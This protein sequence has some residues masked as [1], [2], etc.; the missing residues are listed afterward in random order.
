MKNL[1]KLKGVSTAQRSDKNRTNFKANFKM[2]CARYVN[3]I[4][5]N[6]KLLLLYEQVG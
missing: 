1:M 5:A 4:L 2:K 3:L 6:L